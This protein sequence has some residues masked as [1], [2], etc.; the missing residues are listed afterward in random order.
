[1]A[2]Q[3]IR[4]F[5]L[6]LAVA[7]GLGFSAASKPSLKET[8]NNAI[9]GYFTHSRQRDFERFSLLLLYQH[10]HGRF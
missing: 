10:S 8:R 3:W 6:N 1:M 9:E 7:D 4:S 5:K 2:C